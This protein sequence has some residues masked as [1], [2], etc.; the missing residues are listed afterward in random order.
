MERNPW[1]QN[2]SGSSGTWAGPVG[3]K[4]DGGGSIR[5]QGRV[6]SMRVHRAVH[7]RNLEAIVSLVDAGENINEVEA[8]GN[9]PLHSAAYEG[10]LE[11]VEL[12][13]QLGAK[14]NASNNAGDTPW[15][16]AMNMGHTEVAKLLEQNGA[17]RQ[18]GDVLVPEHVPKVKDF[19]QKDCWKHHPKPYADFL[20]YKQKER[21][22]LEA[23]RK[24]LVRA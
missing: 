24:K 6:G 13:L 12:L 8:A 14:V 11:G 3:V 21:A 9:T 7:N 23:D 1:W 5:G 16:W 2:V 19:Y 20:E 22:E 15:H 4:A 18:K 10:W 17:S